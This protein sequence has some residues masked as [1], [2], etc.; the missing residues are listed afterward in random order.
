MR[1]KEQMFSRGE[2][3]LIGQGAEA[4]IF[5][6]QDGRV[7]KLLRA[8]GPVERVASEV[9]ALEAARSAGLQIPDALEQVVVDGRPGI[10]M[11]RLRGTDLFS[12]MGRK[13]WLV[14]RAGRLTGEIHA[15]INAAR[16][17]AS[18]PKVKDVAQ[19]ILASLGRREPAV[20]LEWI[21]RILARLPDGEAL[22][23]G[24]FHPGQLMVSDGECVAFDWPAAKRG[25]P[26]FDYARTRVLLTMGEPPPG[27]SLLLR[28][29]A[30]VA[31]RLL[32]FSYA[33]SY[34]RNAAEPVDQARLR[35][36]EIVNLAVRLF[37]NIPGE[38][39]RL[40]RR[41]RKESAWHYAAS[42]GSAHVIPLGACNRQTPVSENSPRTK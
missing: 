18:L 27:T 28:F 15:R 17:P 9:A 29:L 2:L 4:E 39:R 19:E 10:V 35:E 33:R 6:L 36:W 23:H 16:A 5:E 26:L 38:R 42:K 1:T 8:R 41:L 3:R 40:L 37:E 25:D 32:V 13:P 14:F 34:E 7:L 30:R 21:G 22:C 20:Q 31:R 24:D 11:E 12:V